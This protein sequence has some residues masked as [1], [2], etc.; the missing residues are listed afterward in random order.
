MTLP[1]LGDSSADGGSGVNTID[2]GT[3]SSE[4]PNLDAGL[5]KRNIPGT[6]A[7]TSVSLGI[8]GRTRVMTV[9]GRISGTESVRNIFIDAADEWLDGE[10]TQVL[11]E[12]RD[13]HNHSR[14]YTCANFT[15]N[16]IRSDQNAIEYT[17]TMIEGK[18]AALELLKGLINAT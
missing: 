3:V 12:F 14:D 11:K 13:S 2:L 17:I 1:R 10:K 15:Y 18:V 4:T 5:F 7:S 9:K 8:M 16:Y 6:P